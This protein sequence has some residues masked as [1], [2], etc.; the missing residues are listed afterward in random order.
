MVPNF[1]FGCSGPTLYL[2][3]GTVEFN[4]QTLNVVK[5]VLNPKTW[6]E[7]QDCDSHLALYFSKKDIDKVC[8]SL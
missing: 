5:Q 8:E 1:K 4:G 6:Y 3:Q 2:C 7:A